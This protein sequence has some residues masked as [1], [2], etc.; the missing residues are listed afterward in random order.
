MPFCPFKLGHGEPR[1]VASLDGIN[2]S[3]RHED[4]RECER[5]RCQ[6]WIAEVAL[7]PLDGRTTPTGSGNC[8][9]VMGYINGRETDAKAGAL[10]SL[11][12]RGMGLAVNK[13]GE[14]VSAK[15]A[16]DA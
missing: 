2:G 15:E 10:V 5:A 9:V 14:I 13:A 11:T 7:N 6:W 3:V 4:P 16:T 8:V 12:L 1:I